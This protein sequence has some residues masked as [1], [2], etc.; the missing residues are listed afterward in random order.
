MEKLDYYNCGICKFHNYWTGICT[1][2][3]S[4][5]FNR[6]RRDEDEACYEWEEST[7]ELED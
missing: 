3:K 7:D 1:E 2:P 6:Y 5:D 4:P